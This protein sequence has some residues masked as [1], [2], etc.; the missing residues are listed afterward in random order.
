MWKYAR[1]MRLPPARR[2]RAMLRLT[3]QALIR[4]QRGGE[5]I[6]YA[7]VAGLIFVGAIAVIGCVGAKIVAR[8]QKL[9]SSL[10]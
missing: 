2:R 6:E 7:V 8:W 5:V 1:L 4:D 10:Q 3:S 9:D